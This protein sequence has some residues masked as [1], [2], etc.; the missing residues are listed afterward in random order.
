MFTNDFLPFFPG[1]AIVRL[2]ET[3]PIRLAEL[4]KAHRGKSV[5]VALKPA[6]SNA[7]EY[8]K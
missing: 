4:C 1:G 5:E 8:V 6:R 3:L 7:I 2:E